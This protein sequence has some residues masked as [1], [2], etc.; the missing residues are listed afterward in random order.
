[1]RAKAQD[2]FATPRRRM[3]ERGLHFDPALVGL[4][5]QLHAAF[6]GA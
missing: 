4:Y 3:K 5:E 6:G 1:M 2:Y